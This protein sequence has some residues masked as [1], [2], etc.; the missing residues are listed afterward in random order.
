MAL[1]RDRPIDDVVDKLDLAL[2]GPG[3]VAKASIAEARSRLGGEP[4]EWLF[5]R[6]ADAWGQASADRHRWRGLGLYG[7]DGSTLRVPD[8]AKN[9]QHFGRHS[10]GTKGRGESAYPMLRIAVL[11][12]LRSH[13]LMAASFGAYANSESHYAA[14]L[15]RFLPAN[16]LVMG[17]RLYFSA[18]TLIPLVRDGENRH[19]LV[20][21][22][23]SLK[24]KVLKRLGPG[25]ELVE[26]TVSKNARQK[27]PS[28]P[29]KWVVR[30]VHYQ[31]RGFRPEVLLTSML[32][33]TLYPAKEI[34]DLYHERW[35]LELGLD[36]IK[37]EILD[38][39]EAI[40]SRTPEGVRQ[41]IWGILLAYNLVRLEMERIAD[42][43]GVQP[44]RISFVVALRYIRD[45]WFW[46][47]GTRSPGA[48]PAHLERMRQNIRRFLLPERRSSRRYPRAVKIKMSGYAKKA[49]PRRKP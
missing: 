48:I 15:W 43:A 45:E 20:R 46:S 5:L 2:P 42:E 28:L 39:E 16:S 21:G 23:S 37:T 44:T 26:F 3:P 38:S 40:R 12:A 17:D 29:K 41:E 30:A 47:Y 1:M 35:E 25:D 33:E 11:M 49:T 18:G 13:V 4:M 22:K 10:K 9:V 27:D 14:D 31:R 36:E 32:D 6:S 8:S 34:R 7:V 19:W 24:W